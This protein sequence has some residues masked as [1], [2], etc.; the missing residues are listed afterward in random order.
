M[1]NSSVASPINF[2]DIAF[3]F[4][5]DGLGEHDFENKHTIVSSVL[6]LLCRFDFGPVRLYDSNVV[7]NVM[8]EK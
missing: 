5:V 6:S 2:V 4:I 1:D 7:T 8:I 3:D